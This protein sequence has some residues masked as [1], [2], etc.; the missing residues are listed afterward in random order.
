[1]A[2]DPPDGSGKRKSK[3]AMSKHS[4]TDAPDDRLAPFEDVN[5]FTSDVALQEALVRE[6][7]GQAQKEL[8]AFGLVCGSADVL[9]EARIA[10][11]HPPRLRSFNPQGQ[12]IDRVEYHPAYHELLKLS[13]REGLHCAA[14]AEERQGSAGQGQQVARAAGLYLA[15]QVNAAHCQPIAMTHAAVPAIA[16]QPEIAAEWMPKI[17]S[18]GYDPRGVPVTDKRSIMI[19][20]GVQESQGG[21]DLDSLRTYAVPAGGAGDRRYLLNGQKWFLTA[22]T[23]DAFLVLAQAPA[24]LSCFLMPRLLSGGETNGL[25]IQRLKDKLGTRAEACA[26]VDISDAEA[27]LLGDEGEG[28]AVLGETMTQ[29]QLDLAVLSAGFMRQSV[30][31]AIHRAEHR[32]VLG[33]PLIEHALMRQVLAD[34]ALDAEA[35]MGLVLRLARSFDRMEDARA[36]AWRR[37]MTPVTKF[38]VC[39]IAPALIAEAIE[40]VGGDAYVEGLPLARNYRD[41]LANML[42]DGTGNDLALEV[43]RVLQREPDAAEAVMEELAKAVGDDP[44]LEAAHARIAAILCEPRRL[45]LRAR[46]LV[47]GLAVLAAGTILRA[48]APAAVADGFI[49]T[50]MGSLARQTY[51]QE[52]DWADTAAILKR[53]SP[54]R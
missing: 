15:A 20:L 24:G 40:C 10:E 19:G 25:H 6:G 51:G 12:R 42:W 52:L 32:T 11:E 33:K 14:W 2:R 16:A 36:A 26:E 31:Q 47:E 5:L 44:Y 35:A 9:D 23:S 53:A 7:G 21:T 39:K 45:D 46:S 17:L 4:A 13:C 27:W 1:M 38:W 49:A 22:P 41:A 50:R 3:A 30:T 48:H 34:L 43:L 28:Q 8:V 18:R 54:N 29:L 37:L